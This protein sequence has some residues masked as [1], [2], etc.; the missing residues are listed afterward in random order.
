MMTAIMRGKWRVTARSGARKKAP[1][2]FEGWGPSD[3][4]GVKIEAPLVI[5]LRSG[6]QFYSAHL[7]SYESIPA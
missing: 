7:T 4:H 3:T 1:S 2:F 5:A 6:S